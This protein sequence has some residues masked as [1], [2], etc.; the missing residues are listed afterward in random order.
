MKI[1]NTEVYGIIYK[2]TNKVNGKVYIGQTVRSFKERYGFSGVGIERVYKYH[3]Y[4]KSIGEKYNK[5][6]LSSIEKYGFD[7]FEVDENFDK[8][9]SKEELN[10][11]EMYWIK[12][13]NSINPNYGYN[14]QEGGFNGKRSRASILKKSTINNHIICCKNDKKI[15]LNSTE[16]SRYYS[17]GKTTILDCIS[18]QRPTQEGLIFIRPKIENSKIV[19]DLDT[20]DLYYN[21]AELGKKYNKDGDRFRKLCNGNGKSIKINGEKRHFIYLRL[22]KKWLLEDI[23]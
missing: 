15:F 3:N 8:S 10:Y 11:K 19:L 20:L 17:V 1:G 22:Y 23:K 9:Y 12:Y 2:I 7:S 5:H 14:N 21:C 13:Y 16:V 6:L 18:E 4:N